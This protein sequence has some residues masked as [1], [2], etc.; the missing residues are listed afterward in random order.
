MRGGLVKRCGCPAAKWPRC[1]H[2][3]HVLKMVRGER[4]RVSL[5]AYLGHG[6]V[7]TVVDAEPIR[8]A[9]LARVRAEGRAALDGTAAPAT[10]PGAP[11]APRTV[12]DLLAR[13]HAH[14]A[15]DAERSPRYLAGLRSYLRALDTAAVPARGTLGAQPLARVTDDLLEV[16]FYD[17][18][19]RYSRSTRNKVLTTVRQV[20]RW[21]ARQGWVA[22]PWLHRDATDV[23]RKKEVRR[24]RRLLAAVG[25]AGESE[26][27]R[28]LAVAGPHLA[29]LIVAGLETGARIGELLQ[30]RWADVDWAA[31]VLAIWD[32][33]DETKPPRRVPLSTRLGLVLE[34]RRHAPD[35]RPHGLA[36]AIF[37]NDVGEPIG[38]VL[39]AWE[40]AVLK[41]HGQ[42]VARQPRTHGLTPAARAAY[43]AIDLRFHD[44]RHEAVSRWVEHGVP[45]GTVMDWTGH[46]SLATL[47]IYK[48]AGEL[49]VQ[50]ATMARFEEAAAEARLRREGPEAGKSDPQV[51]HGPSDGR[52]DGTRR[53]R[54]VTV[55]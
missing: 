50:R 29:D 15:A 42:A 2:G 23:T 11:D 34:G 31:R 26:E 25:P 38:S 30:L 22:R 6:R 48:Q 20:G 51:I 32:A 52:K 10:T 21:A 44:L 43:R 3:W 28:L 46:A 17:A 53:R 7:R 4:I 41:A 54:Q 47:S 1:P 14:R 27:A 39:T 16:A 9:I 5:D 40:N 33:K 12:A 19:A 18:T 35:G 13:F 8:D 55:H 36:A 45:L 49:A 37:G 24:D